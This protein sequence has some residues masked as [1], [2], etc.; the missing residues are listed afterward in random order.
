MS[1][2]PRF[3]PAPLNTKYIEDSH[4]VHR[5]FMCEAKMPTKLLRTKW[6]LK[7]ISK[8]LHS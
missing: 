7:V 6:R 1:T 8:L 2:V 3:I 4:F 5:F